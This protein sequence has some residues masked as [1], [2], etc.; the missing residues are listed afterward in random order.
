MAAFG[1]APWSSRNRA[2]APWPL[3]VATT[4]ALA[5]SGP[6]SL[7]SAPAASRRRADSRSPTLAANSNGVNPPTSV[8]SA[9]LPRLLLRSPYRRSACRRRL[10]TSRLT[11]DRAL[12][13]APWSSSRRT[14]A[15]WRCAVAHIS[16]VWL[17]E[18]SRAFT[19]TPRF[20]SASTASTLPVRAQAISAVSPNA[21]VALAS[22]ARRQQAIHHR[23]VRV[24]TG[25]PER[26]DL[27]VVRRVD[28]GAGLDEQLSRLLVVP[29]DGPV[30]RR[31]TVPL[32][33]TH[34]GSIRQE[35]THGLPS[36]RLDGL[37][38][39]QVV[40]C[41]LKTPAADG[42]EAGGGRQPARP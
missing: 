28:V 15:G 18:T 25:Q 14:T 10:I 29:V 19:S 33:R 17:S 34:V 5:P 38:E 11:R 41:G 24:R 12:G 35:G 27:V 21:R 36:L 2:S 23:P 7:T 8:S 13:S 37:H 31:R 9:S 16:A 30:Q 40:A 6:V 26:R 42:H 39:A 20:R 3:C 32:G 4:R 1:F 22:A